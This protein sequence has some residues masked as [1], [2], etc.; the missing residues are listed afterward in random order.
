MEPRWL[1]LVCAVV[2]HALLVLVARPSYW[3]PFKRSGWKW[4][5]LLIPVLMPMSFATIL[6]AQ[7]LDHWQRLTSPVLVLGGLGIGAATAT[8]IIALSR[9]RSLGA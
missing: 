3:S 7:L 4:P 2:A 1:I 8:V 6:A 9:M 5:D